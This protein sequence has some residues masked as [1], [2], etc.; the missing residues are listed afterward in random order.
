MYA[1]SAWRVIL[2]SALAG[3][4]FAGTI[5]GHVTLSAPAAAL[6]AGPTTVA[7]GGVEE[8]VVWVDSLPAPLQSRYG[9]RGPQ[10]RIVESR[11][12]FFPRVTAV[13]AGTRIQFVNRDDVYHNV[14]SVSPAKRFD[15]GKS[16]PH[17]ESQVTFDQPGVVDLYCDIYPGMAAYVVVAPSRVFARASAAGQFKLPD[18]PSGSYT[19]CAWH[20]AHGIIHRRVDLEHGDVTVAMGF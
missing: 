5:R 2:M 6:A 3:D 12:Q 19:L 10:A 15:L 14:F 20:P 4:A 11:R 13:A 16:P 1:G 18:L 9:G 7:S 17:A 8:T